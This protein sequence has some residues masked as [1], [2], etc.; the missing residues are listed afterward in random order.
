MTNHSGTD[1]DMVSTELRFRRLVEAVCDYAICMLTPEGHVVSW[2]T[3]AQRLQGFVAE[4]ILGRHFSCF[5]PDEA[6]KADAPQQA[7]ESS[8]RDGR[9]ETEGWRVRKD[10]TR[11]WAHVVIDPIRDDDGMLAGFAK[12]TRDITEKKRAAEALEQER[13]ILFQ[14]QKM[15]AIGKLTGGIAHDFNNLLTVIVNSLDL[16][17]NEVHST[18][19]LRLIDSAQAAAGRG[20][21]LTHQLLAF[22]RQ[23]PLRPD[24][25]NINSLIGGFEA[26]LRRAC[27]ESIIFDVSLAPR[28]RSVHVDAAQFESALLNLVVNACEAMPE[29]GHILLATENVTLDEQR[30]VG[31]LAPGF[32]VR[33]TIQDTGCGMSPEVRE[34]AFEPFFTTK[35]M[36]RGT[37]MG[38]SQVYGF[39]VQSGGDVA[40]ESAVGQGTA[41]SLYL[42]AIAGT[43]DAGE[44]QSGGTVGAAT[45]KERV[46]IVEDEPDV[47]EISVELFRSMGYEVITAGNSM[48]AIDILKR[49]RDIDVLFA[50]IVMP[51]GMHGIELARFTQK[52]CP[53]IRIVLASGYPVP[54]LAA[55]HGDLQ[56][57]AFVSKPYRWTELMQKLR[58]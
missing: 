31:A 40:I 56:G 14:S 41:V 23:Q 42:P 36:G 4:E 6:V 2:N 34:R 20:A 26:I 50:D 1:M 25:Y 3:G 29:G 33:L 18:G 54:A 28:L 10:G 7:L 37:G 45:R 57:M 52:L 15:D 27:R 43:A 49:T 38:L 24:N 32:Y 9:F 8:A 53:G 5:Y 48:D 35:E 13:A 44:V 30:R 19:G 51:K 39:V 46:L 22:A 16:L 17:S 12:I 55:R 11:F 21:V 47:L 58:S